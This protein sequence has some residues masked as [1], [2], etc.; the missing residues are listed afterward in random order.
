MLDATILD[1]YLINEA[2]GIVGRPILTACVD[3]YSGLCCGYSLSWEGGVYSLRNLMLN[4]I[5]DKV[6]HCRAFGIA[7][8]RQDWDCDKLSGKV[9]KF[10][11]CIQGY[12]RNQLKGKGVVEPDFQERGVHDYRKDACLTVQCPF[13]C[14][15]KSL[16]LQILRQIDME[17]DTHYYD[18]AVR[19]RA[20]TDML[21]GSVSQIALN[22]IGL[23]V[24]D[25][26]QNIVNHRQ[27]K[28]MR[29]EYL[30]NHRKGLY[31]HLLTSGKLNGHLHECD[32]EC[33]ERM[34]FL[35]EQMKAGA[36]ITEELKA[37]EQIVAESGNELEAG[38]QVL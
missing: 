38:G 27:G 30:K 20:T 5:A 11:D 21:I 12:Y 32:E 28:N 29:L 36:G 10:F 22:H 3:A 34:E 8:N 18:M 37:K 14:S 13:N 31:L 15:V 23:L 19:A 17:L 35:T 7:I 2:G 4:V 26:I 25:E 1:I 6:E 16:L 33:R 9:E 24:V